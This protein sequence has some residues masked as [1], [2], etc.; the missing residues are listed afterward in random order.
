[1]SRRADIELEW[2][3]GD[4]LFALKGAQIEELEAISPN[5]LTGK[6]GI[7]LGAI[8]QRV[9]GGGWHACDIRNIIRLGM[10][11]GGMGAVEANRLCKTYVDGV[12]IS[13]ITP[14]NASPNAPLLVAQAILSAAVI[15]VERSGDAGEPQTPEK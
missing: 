12:P 4:V 1:M 5:P 10:I 11:G 8:W 13:T 9:M 15:G 3:P 2:G 6:P 14:D 7:G